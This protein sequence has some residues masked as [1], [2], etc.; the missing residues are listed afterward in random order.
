MPKVIR[1]LIIFVQ[2]QTSTNH[3]YGPFSTY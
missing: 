1:L 3:A 2:K